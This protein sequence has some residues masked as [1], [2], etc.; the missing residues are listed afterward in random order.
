MY[1]LSFTGFSQSFRTMLDVLSLFR[2]NTLIA[3]LNAADISLAFFGHPVPVTRFSGTLTVRRPG[4]A[5]SIFLSLIDEIDGAYFRPSFVAL[6]PWQICREHWQLLYLAFD[7]AREPLYLFS[8]DQVA[9][10]NEEAGKS[11]HRGLDLFEHL[12]LESERRLGFRC[13]GPVVEGGGGQR[14]GRHEVHVAYALAAGKPVP[15]AVID[16]YTSMSKFDSDLQWAKPLL[17]VLNCAVRCRFPSSRRS[18]A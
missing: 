18:R 10:A 17:V 7:L 1:Q 4:T 13:A 12:R 14:N 11:G 16:D 6:E 3:G 9:H 15:Q 2:N 5:T 8:S